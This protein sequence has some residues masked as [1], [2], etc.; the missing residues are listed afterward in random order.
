MVINHSGFLVLVVRS[1]LGAHQICCLFEVS[2]IQCALKQHLLGL[3]E[4]PCFAGFDEELF[5][6]GF[7]GVSDRQI[8]QSRV[9]A[10]AIWLSS[11]LLLL[12]FFW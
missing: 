11:N 1:Q 10:G 3:L 8:C 4:V 7:V 12:V 6:I 5:E 9:G 2:F